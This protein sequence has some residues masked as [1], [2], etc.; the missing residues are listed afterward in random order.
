MT[1]TETPDLDDIDEAELA[2]LQ[3]ERLK[4]VRAF[5]SAHDA[6]ADL[7]DAVDQAIEDNDAWLD[8]T[9]ETFIEGRLST[10]SDTEQ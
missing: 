5:L 4:A 6:D 2:L 9:T 7:V 1:I 3:R 10:G 8:A